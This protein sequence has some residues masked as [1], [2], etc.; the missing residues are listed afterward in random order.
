MAC[1]NIATYN[2]ELRKGDDKTILFRYLTDGLPVDL[3]SS[4]IK[5]QTTIPTLVQDAIIA[6]PTDGEFTVTFNRADTAI[7]E[8]SRVNY[9]VELWPSGLSGTK[10]T[11]FAGEIKLTNEVLV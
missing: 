10:Q 4:T 1:S 6:N 2:F 11:L 7:L 9:E 3:S 5:F 8:D